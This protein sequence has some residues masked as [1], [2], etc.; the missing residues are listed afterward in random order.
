MSIVKNGSGKKSRVR[1]AKKHRY[2]LQSYK[3]KKI[4]YSKKHSG[5]YLLFNHL[6]FL[7]HAHPLVVLD[8]LGRIV[9]T[10]S[11]GTCTQISIIINKIL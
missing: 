8:P 4:Q 2:K 9:R 5:L 10:T 3:Q 7:E 6:R 1:K 11:R